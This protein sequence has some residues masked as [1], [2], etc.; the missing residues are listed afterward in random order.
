MVKNQKILMLIYRP[1]LKDF[2]NT[3][4]FTKSKTIKAY[5]KA[6][7]GYEKFIQINVATTPQFFYSKT[8]LKTKMHKDKEISEKLYQKLFIE[9]QNRN[10]S[11]INKTIYEFRHYGNSFR[12]IIFDNLVNDETFSYLDGAK[13]ACAETPSHLACAETLSYIAGA[14]T[15]AYLEIDLPANTTKFDFPDI[16]APKKEYLKDIFPLDNIPKDIS[17]DKMKKCTDFK[18][19]ER[20]SIY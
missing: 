1:D 2:E 19:A 10:L 3:F 18:I 4:D 17:A 12:L 13:L 11:L 16:L 7:E 9:Q 20:K 5:L 6:K 14:K 15:F 8:D